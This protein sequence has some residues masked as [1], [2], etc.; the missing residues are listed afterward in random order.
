MAEMS[1]AATFFVEG[2]PQAFISECSAE[3]MSEDKPVKTLMLGVAGYS[4]GSHSG[5]YSF[6]GAIPKAGRETDFRRLCINHITTVCSFKMG[7]STVQLEGRFMN[8]TERCSVDN[9]NEFDGQFEG[10]IISVS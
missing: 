8:V 2:I 1:K 7:G 4:D 9:P 6:K 10:R 3:Y 5:K